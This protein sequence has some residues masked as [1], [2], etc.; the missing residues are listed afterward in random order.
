MPNIKSSK[1]DMRRSRVAAAR[2]KAQQM[3]MVFIDQ[4]TEGRA[5]ASL[6]SGN[7]LCVCAWSGHDPAR[8]A[9]CCE[10]WAMSRATVRAAWL[11]GWR[12]TEQRVLQG[13]RLR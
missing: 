7:Q 3:V 11:A 4:V 8:P 5:V 10:S 6:N 1:K 12:K 13:R 9:I 2:N